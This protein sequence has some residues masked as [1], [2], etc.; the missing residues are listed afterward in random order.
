M[1]FRLLK[2]LSLKNFSLKGLWSRQSV[3]VWAGLTLLGGGIGT[4]ANLNEVA[5]IFSPDQTTEMVADARSAAVSADAKID[6][7]LKLMRIQAAL[8]GAEFDPQ[9][10]RL[11]TTAMEA[12]LTSGDARKAAAREALERG[13]VAGAAA[14]IRRVAAD[15][16]EAAGGAAQAAVESWKEAGALSGPRDPGAAIEAYQQALRLAPDDMEALISLASTHYLMGDFAAAAAAYEQARSF[17]DPSSSEYGWA[18]QGLGA[19]AFT[20]GRV[21]EAE[22]FYIE[23][24]ALAAR[25]DDPRLAAVSTINLAVNE[26]RRGAYDEA[27]KSLR[28]SIEHARKADAPAYEA[29]A[30]A[31]LGLVEF[32]RGDRLAGVELLKQANEMYETRGELRHQATTLGNLGAMALEEG[33][34][35]TAETYIAQSVDLGERLGLKQSVAED[36]TNLAELARQRADLAAAAD[37]IERATAIAEEIELENLK[38]FLATTSA[39]IAQDGGDLAKACALYAE[40][41]L[42]FALQQ[43]T[44]KKAV[45]E[46]AAKAGCTES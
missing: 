10:E 23:A 28:R 13:D 43:D 7:I 41:S 33:D 15:Q 24:M 22:K 3:R 32:Q 36:L 9:S 44:T 5:D 27:E 8:S 16:S 12:I 25:I 42:S 1:R 4:I 18:T 38:P 17:V 20:R 19:V 6:E 21:E 30:T 2:S 37:Y 40:A 46:L 45:D 35:E 11:I 14:A 39:Q 31:Q 34:T 29:R 26:R